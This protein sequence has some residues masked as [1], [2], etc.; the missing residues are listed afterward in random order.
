MANRTLY[1]K[2]EDEKYWDDAKK[3]LRVHTEESLS[4]YITKHL[5]KLVNESKRK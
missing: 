1:V 4:S 3:F 2:E 5:K